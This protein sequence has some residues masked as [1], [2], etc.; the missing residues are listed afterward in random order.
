MAKL[1]KNFDAYS[2]QELCADVLFDL[3]VEKFEVYGRK[4][5]IQNGIDLRSQ[6]RVAQC[7]F[8]S[9]D[10][11]DPYGR[12]T[13]QIEKD[14]STAC[15]HFEFS[16]F[17][18]ITSLNRDTET[19]DTI[20]HLRN[21]EHLVSIYFWEDIEEIVLN[22]RELLKLHF[23]SYL[24]SHDMSVLEQNQLLF[25]QKFVELFNQYNI[26]YLVIEPRLDSNFDISVFETFDALAEEYNF[27]IERYSSEQ[28]Y[29]SSRLRSQIVL[30][31]EQ[32]NDYYSFIACRTFPLDEN[33]AMPKKLTYEEFETYRSYRK[34]LYQNYQTALYY[35]K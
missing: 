34:T 14:F 35:L 10:T 9:E 22:D 1:A 21:S 25:K 8:Y 6:T 7:K 13:N 23:S 5:Q 24:N 31:F 2:F 3:Y 33:T 17:I 18:V 30:F 16:E 4:G 11:K 20:R 27:L 29:I 26:E 12:L 32:L 28:G 19:Q 15:M